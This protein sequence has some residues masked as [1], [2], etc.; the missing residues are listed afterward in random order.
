MARYIA[1][2]RQESV[3][4]ILKDPKKYDQIMRLY[5]ANVEPGQGL[6]NPY[7]KVQLHV[8]IGYQ[9]GETDFQQKFQQLQ[10]PNFTYETLSDDQK[11]ALKDLSNNGLIVKEFRGVL[12]FESVT[13]GSLSDDSRDQRP[14]KRHKKW[15]TIAEVSDKRDAL[16]NG[17][18][19]SPTGPNEVV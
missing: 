1:M 11:V 3:L 16:N 9:K 2:E 4:Q 8:I 6:E 15:K 14:Y 7:L 17:G 13:D 18:P 19:P 12:P 10:D 5:N